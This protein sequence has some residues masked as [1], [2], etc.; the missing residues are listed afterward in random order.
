MLLEKP[1]RSYNKWSDLQK[2]EAV[3]SCLNGEMKSEVMRRHGITSYT[4]LYKW[5]G[6]FGPSILAEELSVMPKKDQPKPAKSHQTEEE[7]LKARIVDLERQ[8][9]D[10]E[11]KAKLL[12]KMID[13]AE[14]DLKVSIRKKSGPRQSASSK[15][16]RK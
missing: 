6:K 1:F 2:K 11:L 9:E 12:D 8:L 7:V 4:V 5:I 14:E 16:R 3:R 10:A 15:Q 13:I